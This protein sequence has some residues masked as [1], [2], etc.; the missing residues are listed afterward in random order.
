MTTVRLD[1]HVCMYVCMYIYIYIYIYILI[2][3]A[4]GRIKCKTDSY[5]SNNLPGNP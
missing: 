4:G 1:M 5:R 3:E 2:L